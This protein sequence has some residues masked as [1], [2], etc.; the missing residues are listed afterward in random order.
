MDYF[1]PWCLLCGGT[2]HTHDCY[3]FQDGPTM[4]RDDMFSYSHQEEE[5]DSPMLQEVPSNEATSLIQS[6][7]ALKNLIL[8]L[9]KDSSSCV[10][11]SDGE[12]D[13]SFEPRIE[14]SFDKVHFRRCPASTAQ[15]EFATVSSWE[16]EFGDELLD[17]PLVEG[18]NE[19]FDPVG[20]LVE[21]QMLLYG[22][23]IENLQQEDDSQAV[24]FTNKSKTMVTPN[25]QLQIEYNQ[26]MI[27]HIDD[28][29]HEP[30]TP[31]EKA[32]RSTTDQLGKQ[33]IH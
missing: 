1:Q 13:K 24:G 7:E 12:L 26:P 4:F 23:P 22:K 31:R 18:K 11:S 10:D 5:F 28:S 32:Y 33:A 3:Y 8:D 20:D 25:P 21:L 16:E 29:S 14:I 15:S 19:N 30:T 27:F 9:N 2:R 6:L 17:L